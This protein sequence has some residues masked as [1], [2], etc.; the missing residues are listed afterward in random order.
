MKKRLM[1]ILLILCV[2]LTLLPMTAFAA[3]GAATIKNDWYYLRCMDNYLNITADGKAELRKLSKNEAFYVESKGGGAFTLKMKDGRYL[4]LEGTRKEGMRVIAVSK[5]YTWNIYAEST[6]FDT[7]KTDIFSLRPPEVSTMLVNASG[8]KNADGTPIIIWTH[9]AK[10]G[11]YNAPEHGEFRFITAYTSETPDTTGESWKTYKENGLIGYKDQ[12]GKVV[13]PAQFEEARNFSQ[14][15]AR[16]R[17]KDK[18]LFAYIDTTGKFITPSKYYG[19]ICDHTVRDGLM[20][21]GTWGDDITS[22]LMNGERLDYWVDEKGKT[23][24]VMKS[25]ATFNYSMKAGFI[26]TTG[27]E[28]IPLQFDEANSFQNDM[29]AVYKFQGKMGN[30]DTNKVGWIDTTGKL[31]IPYMSDGD[32]YYDGNV[33]NFKD[34]L[35]C[36]FVETDK[37]PFTLP[38]AGIIDKTGKVIIPANKDEW[39]HSSNFGLL[40]RDGVIAVTPTKEVNAKGVPTKGGGHS[41]SFSSLYDYSGKLIK[42]LEGYVYALPIVGGYTLAMHQLPEDVY[43]CYWTVFDRSGNIVIDKAESNNFNLLNQGVGIENGYIFFGDSHYEISSMPAPAPAPIPPAAPAKQ[44][45]APAGLIAKPMDTKFMLN[46][47]EVA[48]PAY[49][50][51]S[52]NYVKLR[53]VGAL[54][55]TRFDVRWEDGKVKLYNHAAYS[56]VGGELV[57]IGTDSK[58]AIPSNTEFMLFDKWGQWVGNVADL[59]AYNIGG[60]NYTKLRDIAKLFDFDV[61]WRDGKVWIEP[62]VS[63]YTED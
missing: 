33:H 61:D 56:P 34:G 14:G 3:G 2:A 18:D 60:N 4:G 24:V 31:V 52:N 1:S 22:A 6:N 54:L 44:P 42:K 50:I 45:S 32:L 10:Y 12:N 16:V 46:G 28:V 21:V 53:D 51:S 20:R 29:A 25:G 15:I 23:I 26:D 36:Y 9:K 17:A 8:E 27:K 41:W 48:L 13:I 49:N 19:S 59:T 30:V 58:S 57:A 35:V 11:W 43:S 55:K 5:P 37:D 47:A 63:P 40:W 7:E 38:M 39:F 62:D